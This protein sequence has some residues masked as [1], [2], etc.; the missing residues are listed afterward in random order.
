MNNK[1]QKIG[2]VMNY[3]NFLNVNLPKSY[4]EP[5]VFDTGGTLN[6]HSVILIKA[7][8]RNDFQTEKHPWTPCCKEIFK[9]FEVVG[10]ESLAISCFE[11]KPFSGQQENMD[12]VDRM[13]ADEVLNAAIDYASEHPKLQVSFFAKNKRMFEIYTNTLETL[14]KVYGEIPQVRVL[15]GFIGNSG[16]EVIAMSTEDIAETQ[17]IAIQRVSDRK[18]LHDAQGQVMVRAPGERAMGTIEDTENEPIT[19]KEKLKDT[20]EAVKAKIGN[21]AK[22]D[23]M[24][25]KPRKTHGPVKGHTVGEDIGDEDL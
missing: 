16:S 23:E 25:P 6:S 9:K 22:E 12:S 17:N 13:I 10:K 8:D 11:S 19:F 2:V 18:K 5:A 7:P 24:I 21:L 14:K 15:H 1:H 20:K 4:K 3:M